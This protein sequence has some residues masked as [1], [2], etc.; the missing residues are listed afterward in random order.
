MHFSYS[1]NAIAAGL[2]LISRD[3]RQSLV[4]MQPVGPNL[5]LSWLS[6]RRLLAPLEL[7]RE[8]EESER[9]V[10]ELR[11]RPSS[12]TH[13]LMFFSGGNQQ[14]VILARWMSSGA[15]T[16]IFDEPTRGIDVGAKAEVFALMSRLVNEGAAIL[17]ISSE[18][19]EL[20]GMAD[21]VLVL[22]GGRVTAELDR[23]QLSQENL[24]RHAS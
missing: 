22:H 7:K 23:D 19:N 17:M 3:R 1:S 21:R 9:Y 14:K 18:L 20:I 12:L 8:R 24:L 11:V 5:S 16:L 2:G 6:R 15:H 4:P 13:Q 10:K